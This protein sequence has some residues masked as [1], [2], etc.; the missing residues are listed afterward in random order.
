LEKYR[1]VNRKY[2]GIGEINVS[3]PLAPPSENHSG[4][5]TTTS[6]RGGS[7]K[8]SEEDVLIGIQNYVCNYIVIEVAT[9]KRL[10]EFTLSSSPQHMW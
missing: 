8:E 6:K 5:R 3:S 7:S 2:H 4:C 10:L 1:K 9:S